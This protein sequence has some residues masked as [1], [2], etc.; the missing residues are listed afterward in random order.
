[1]PERAHV[2][3]VE[4]LDTFRASLIIYVSKARPTLEEVSA[5]VTRTRVW[6][7]NDARTHWESQVRRRAKAL[8][9]AKQALFSSR[10]SDLRE[11]T[12]S[13]QMAVHKAKRAFDEAEAKLK[14]LKQ[15]TREYDSRVEPLLKQLAKLHT[16]LSNDM[17][18]AAAYLTQAINTL[19]AYADVGLS[20]ASAGPAGSSG[21]GSAD[22]GGGV[23]G[24]PPS[25]AGSQS[26][27]AGGNS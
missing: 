1:M 20:T 4:A 16:V 2:T 22:G 10:I 14:I 19:A 12:T 13:E 27:P 26:A 24:A 8:E 6:L 11:V 18:L 9:E 21:Q 25:E 17:L 15:W 23:A 5:D 7:E 3:S